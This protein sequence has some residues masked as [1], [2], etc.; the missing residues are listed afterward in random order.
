M[1]KFASGS[2]WYEL[3]LEGKKTIDCRLGDYR[4]WTG[5][6][7]QIVSGTQNRMIYVN[8]VLYYSSVSEMLKHEDLSL[9]LPG[10]ETS[11]KSYEIFRDIFDTDWIDGAV[12]AFHFTIDSIDI[13]RKIDIERRMRIFINTDLKLSVGKWFS[14]VGHIAQNLGVEMYAK[15]P[16]MYAEY[17]SGLSTKIVLRSTEKDMLEMIEKYSDGKVEHEEPRCLYIRDAGRTQ[18]KPNSLT[19][20]GFFPTLIQPEEVKMLNYIDGTLPDFSY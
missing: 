4:K 19:V 8:R 17:M 13:E 9:L 18:C 16:D 7:I 6:H 12:S 20:L 2:K 15:Y 11:T 10:V 14:Q 1:L 3:I 5:R